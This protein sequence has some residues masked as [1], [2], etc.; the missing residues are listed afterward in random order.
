MPELSIVILNWNTRDLLLRCVQTVFDQRDDLD[1]E[2][3]VVDNA[4]TDDSAAAVRA[5]FPGVRV[6]ESGANVGF[7]RGN[8]IG[9]AASAAPFALLLNTDAFFTPGALRALLTVA[10]AQPRAGMVGA[11]LINADGS[12]QASHSPFPGHMQE[13][14]ILS[15]LGRKLRGAHYPSHGPEE[16]K[17]PQQV[18]Y[19]EGACLLVRRAAY[20]DVGGLDAGYFMYAEEVDLC[21]AMRQRGWQVWYQPQAQV[22]HLG[23][24]SSANRRTQR[25]TDLYRS[26]IRFFRKH[27][28]RASASLLKAQIV[29]TVAVKSAVHGAA[30]QLSGGKRGRR[31]PPLAD[32]ARL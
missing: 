15:G 14:L 18:D 10:Q 7:A 22:I 16:A 23:G 8:N 32:V 2:V 30:Y 3:I 20:D 11:R 13:F 26:R 1:V 31:M 24:A 17:G 12:F 28:G 27:Y 25:E 21:Y 5:H 9:V 6:I 4:S 19:V 29:T